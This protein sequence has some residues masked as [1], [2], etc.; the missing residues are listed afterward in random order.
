MRQAKNKTSFTLDLRVY[1]LEAIYLAAYSLLD[2]FYIFLDSS[3]PQKV[4]VSLKV[5]GGSSSQKGDSRGE[6][7][8][9]LLNA[10]LRL[11]VA[12]LGK[13]VR[14]AIIGQALLSSLGE[15]TTKEEADFQDDPLG[16]ATPW[17]EKYGNKK[18]AKK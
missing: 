2:R 7:Y 8:N 10:S 14:E 6:F 17:E 1:P 3:S 4:K 15:A 11:K 16:I 18:K 9:E 12:K 13:K 5:K